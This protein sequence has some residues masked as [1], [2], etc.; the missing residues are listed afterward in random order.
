MK[1]LFLNLYQ[2]G[3]WTGGG[4]SHAKAH[5]AKRLYE[6]KWLSFQDGIVFAAKENNPAIG[7]AK[8]GAI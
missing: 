7:E 2:R 4:L 1:H 5:H 8:K 6:V 3:G